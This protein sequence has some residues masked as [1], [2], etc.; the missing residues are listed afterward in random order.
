MIAAIR[1]GLL[2]LLAGPFRASAKINRDVMLG[3]MR[4]ER[5]T[6]LELG[7]GGAPLL[8][9]L[10]GLDTSKKIVLEFEGA[11]D[12]SRNLGYRCLAQ[13]MGKEVWDLPDDSVDL[14]VS[15]QVLEHIPH[16]DH[17]MRETLRV[18]RPGGRVLVSVPNPGA[19]AYIVMMLLTINPPMSMVSDEYYGLGNPFSSRRFQRSAEF[20]TEGHGHLRLFTIRGMNDLLKVHGFKALRS[21]GGT[22][23][24]PLVG[25]FL[26][27]VL[28]WY[29][30]LTIVLAEK[31]QR[32]SA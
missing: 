31:P 29:G 13:D 23:A 5:G 18:L 11:L 4:G 25:R 24:L 15:S 6:V 12:A 3:F 10:E 17:V 32:P 9:D 7:P 16:T 21:H 26:G 1:R 28:P 30:L 20:G 19:L 2:Q 22:W 27:R 8:R 14:V